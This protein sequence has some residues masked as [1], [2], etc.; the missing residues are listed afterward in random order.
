MVH[1][2]QSGRGSLRRRRGSLSAS[3][4]H[5]PG[6]RGGGRL[7]RGGRARARPGWPRSRGPHPIAHDRRSGARAAGDAL[8]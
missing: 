4:P 5:P 1:D 8:P 7:Q 3:P 6:V 2:G